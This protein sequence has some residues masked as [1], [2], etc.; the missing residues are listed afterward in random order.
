MAIPAANRAHAREF[1]PRIKRS[2]LRQEKKVRALTTPRIEKNSCPP[3]NKP[4]KH[5][6][7][8]A[9][10]ESETPTIQTKCA[11][12]EKA[13]LEQLDTDDQQQDLE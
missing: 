2:K 5:P 6:G 11:L 4:E 8:R 13:I 1:R 7:T 10:R 3:I 9:D 12:Q